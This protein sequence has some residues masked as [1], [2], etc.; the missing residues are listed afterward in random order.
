MVQFS[1]N[2]VVEGCYYGQQ[3][4][5]N[6]LNTRIQLRQFPDNPLRPNFDPRPVPT[7]YSIFPI[8]DRKSIPKTPMHSYLDNSGF[9]PVSH[10]GPPKPFLEN[11]DTE[12]ILRNQ[13]VALQHGAGQGVFVPSYQSDLYMNP[14]YS[15]PY[16]AIS[17]RQPHP[18][19]FSKPFLINRE[20]EIKHQP[21]GKQ[22]FHNNTRTQLRNMA[23]QN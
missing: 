9:V 23:N 18:E 19:L 13:T 1:D 14:V 16:Y 17:A 2:G 7:K 10:N 11:I 20:H 6:E 22:L 5:V 4:R 8:I 15:N 21:I 12:T 3:D